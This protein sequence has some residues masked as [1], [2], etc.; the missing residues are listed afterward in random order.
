MV[1]PDDSNRFTILLFFRNPS[2]SPPAQPQQQP[3]PQ[4]QAPPYAPPNGMPFPPNAAFFGH[5]MPQMNPMMGQGQFP[6]GFNNGF[7]YVYV[8]LPLSSPHSSLSVVFERV[9]VPKPILTRTNHFGMW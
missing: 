8:F 1:K 7:V 5:G 9:C 6:M 4:Q 2:T 3:P